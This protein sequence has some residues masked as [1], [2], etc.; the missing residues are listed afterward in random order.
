MTLDIVIQSH[1]SDAL[2][3]MNFNNQQAQ[4]RIQ[5]VKFLINK[6]PD[7]SMEIS[8]EILDDLYD[9]CFYDE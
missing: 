5:F 1:L 7:L 2:I 6:Y 9:E 4:D 3:E 8:N